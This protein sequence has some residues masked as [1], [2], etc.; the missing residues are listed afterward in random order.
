METE[1]SNTKVRIPDMMETLKIKDNTEIIKLRAKVEQ[2]EKHLDEIANNWI[3]K[4]ERD[5]NGK[6]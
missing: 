3:E 2:L 1:I 4:L 6:K 5:N